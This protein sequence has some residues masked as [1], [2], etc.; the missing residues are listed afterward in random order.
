MAD[1]PVDDDAYERG[2]RRRRRTLSLSQFFTDRQSESVAFMESV[3][4]R[5]RDLAENR[6]TTT[7]FNNLL[8]YYGFG[9]VGK[10]QISLGLQAWIDG[11]GNAPTHWGVPPAPDRPIVTARWEFNDS[12]GNLDPVA[13]LLSVRSALHDERTKGLPPKTWRA[14]DIAFA[15]YA[16]QVRPGQSLDPTSREGYAT[17]LPKMVS[18]IA[19]EAT[20]GFGAGVGAQGLRDAAL[21]ALRVVRQRRALAENQGLADLVDECLNAEPGSVDAE[22]ASD[23]LFLIDKAIRQMP[24]AERPLLIVFVDHV[25]KIQSGDA[26]TRNGERLLNQLVGALPH[27][28][29]VM[30]GR[31]VLD[32]NDAK[33]TSL[34]HAGSAAWPCLERNIEIRTRNPRPH[35]L[36]TL[37]KV[38]ARDW[39]QRQVHQLDLPFAPG[40]V[41]NLVEVTG[42]W[43]VHIDAVFVLA[44]VKVE[45]GVEELTAKDLDGSFDDVVQRLLDDL[46]ADERTALQTACLLPY[47]NTEF[48]NAIT[49][50]E[51]NVGTLERLV[52]RSVV[53]KNY[54]SIYDY[55]IHDE[56][57]RAV[58]RA[59]PLISRGWDRAD[60]TAR[61]KI[62][63]NHAIAAAKVARDVKNDEE[64]LAAV[65]LAIT[66]AA[67]YG[68]SA[69]DPDEPE[70]DAIVAARRRAPSHSSL[71]S[72][73][74]A[75]DGVEYEDPRAAIR[76]IELLTRPVDE[77]VINQLADVASRPTPSMSDALT[78]RGYRLRTLDRCAEAAEQFQWLR[79][80]A[81]DRHITQRR[82][83]YVRQLGTSYSIGRRFRD[84]AEVMPDM[85]ADQADVN[86]FVDRALHGHIDDA[87]LENL[88]TRIANANARFAREL[89][90]VLHHRLAQIGK[91][92]RMAAER[93]M[94]SATRFNDKDAQRTIT[95][96]LALDDFSRG[97][98]VDV[99]RSD[100]FAT[101]SPGAKL[102]ELLALRA[103]RDGIDDTFRG[104]LDSAGSLQRRA[105]H[106]IPV[107]MLLD[108]LGYPLPA[109]ETQWLEPYEDVRARWVGHYQALLGR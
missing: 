97:G 10:T 67:E 61:A 60:W 93:A 82:R 13:L 9:G 30:T 44:Q 109:V 14:F 35:L 33:R 24:P 73:I 86:R 64:N 53:L 98:D 34:A 41:D 104:W 55:R 40:V 31:N 76:I 95:V 94:A 108:H 29:F 32:W 105:R 56:V 4:A 43:P 101:K 102:G 1:G 78:W 74:P 46:P 8:L 6:L 36:E 18:E 77:D 7:S 66:I 25:E 71:L 58:R 63:L 59:G 28:L 49:G 50:D 23:V 75:S 62:A 81:P 88:R 5:D 52:G 69:Q 19:I 83:L 16:S 2:R 84:A 3:W 89:T 20:V 103:L 27:A 106:W 79:D 70:V 37:S 57:R 11:T 92:D 65:G 15:A 80:N 68:V 51:V 45:D 47:F 100:L 39:I 99:A 85:D 96:A 72:R 42:R 12:G 17:E 91:L 90:S 54:D 26:V 38:D 107:E 22:L 48:V 21:G 87:Y